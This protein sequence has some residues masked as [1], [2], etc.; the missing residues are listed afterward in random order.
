MKIMKALNIMADITKIPNHVY[1]LWVAIILIVSTVFPIGTR[2]YLELRGRIEDRRV[3]IHTIQQMTHEKANETQRMVYQ[4]I[5]DLRKASQI[6]IEDLRKANR[7]Q[8]DELRK[9][10]QSQLETLKEQISSVKEHNN[11]KTAEIFTRLS[12]IEALLL[13]VRKDIRLNHGNP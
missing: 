2:A 4:Q 6:Q 5:E 10:N 11:V 12:S 9:S 7:A 13:E 8:I 3:E 1:W